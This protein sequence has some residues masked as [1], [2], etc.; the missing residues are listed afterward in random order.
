[1]AVDKAAILNCHLLIKPIFVSLL[2]E[3]QFLLEG[4]GHLW[5]RGT[6]QAE[7]D[8]HGVVDEPLQSGQSTDHDDTGNQALPNTLKGERMGEGRCLLEVY[9]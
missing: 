4:L 1:M 7:V 8:L 9:K 5:G 3:A 2:G 6:G